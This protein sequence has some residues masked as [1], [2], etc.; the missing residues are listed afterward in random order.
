PSM[1]MIALL[2]VIRKSGCEQ[3]VAGTTILA[4]LKVPGSAAANTAAAHR[5]APHRPQN[6]RSLGTH[7]TGGGSAAAPTPGRCLRR[8]FLALQD[9]VQGDASLGLFRFCR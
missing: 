5:V 1:W 3:W 9:R 4:K 7:S 8:R 6:R 2:P